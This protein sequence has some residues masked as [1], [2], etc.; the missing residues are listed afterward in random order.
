MH[1]ILGDT[2]QELKDQTFEVVRIDPQTATDGSVTAYDVSV[3]R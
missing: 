2:V 1:R 3:R